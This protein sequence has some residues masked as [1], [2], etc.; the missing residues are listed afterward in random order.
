FVPMLRAYLSA[1]LPYDRRGWGLGTVE[2]SYAL[3]GVAGLFLAGPLISIFSC[4]LPFFLLGGGLLVAWR[5]FGDLD[6]GRPTSLRG[7]VRDRDRSRGWSER[8]VAS[9]KFNVHGRSA[10]ATVVVAGLSVFA[11]LN[12]IIAHGVWLSRE[13]GFTAAHLG[14]LALLLGIAD[15]AGTALVTLA[16]EPLGKPRS[17]RLRN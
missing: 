2:Y 17:V 4:R 6:A 7:L 1:R 10:W 14:S 3:A 16:V 12:I 8:V 9:F 11:E 5:V 15:F 13:Y